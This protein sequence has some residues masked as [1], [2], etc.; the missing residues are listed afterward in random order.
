MRII[1]VRECAV[2]I[3]SS[4]RNSSFD[5]SEMTTSVVAV[6]TNVLRGGKAGHRFRVQFDGSLCVRSSDASALHPAHSGRLIR[7]R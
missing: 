6:R 5:F 7:A 2:A 1:D 3:N 4:I